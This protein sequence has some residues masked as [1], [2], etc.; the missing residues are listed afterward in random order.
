MTNI[1]EN[2]YI[3]LSNAPELIELRKKVS[4]EIILPYYEKRIKKSM[5][6]I[7]NYSFLSIL[8]YTLSSIIMTIATAISFTNIYYDDSSLSIIEGSLGIL[9]IILKEYGVF[10]QE[11][12]QQ[13][14]LKI[15]ALLKAI[16]IKDKVPNLSKYDNPM[17]DGSIKSLSTTINLNN[18][19][20]SSSLINS[21]NE[22]DLLLKVNPKEYTSLLEIEEIIELRKKIILEILLPHYEKKIH[23]FINNTIQWGTLSIICYIL[24]SIVIGSASI[25]SFIN[26]TYNKFYLSLISGILSLIAIFVKEFGQFSHRRDK[27]NSNKVNILL[28]TIGINSTVPDLSKYSDNLPNISN[29]PF[30]DKNIKL[31]LV[32][33]DNFSFERN[34]SLT[35]DDDD[36]KNKNPILSTEPPPQIKL[37]LST[38]SHQ[39]INLTDV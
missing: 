39:Q 28:R 16:G 6:H 13:N 25:I 32:S 17:A 11:R 37:T 36:E 3:K 12:E 35:I 22:I 26:Q 27:Q 38:E 5:S 34:D 4:V 8:F 18:S 21:I 2:N 31:R 29:N 20:V 30:D 9:S 15:N 10:C 14:S 23:S 1:D 19:T 33:N 24:S 7:S